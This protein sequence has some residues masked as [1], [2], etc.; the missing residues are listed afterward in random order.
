MDR[1]R[2]F[3]FTR[4]AFWGAIIGFS[5]DVFSLRVSFFHR[6][7]FGTSGRQDA[8]EKSTVRRAGAGCDLLEKLEYSQP[9]PRERNDSKSSLA[10]FAVPFSLKAG[11]TSQRV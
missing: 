3:F 2:F 10:F 4:F 9:Q 1:T 11:N 8:W 7:S 5:R 6:R